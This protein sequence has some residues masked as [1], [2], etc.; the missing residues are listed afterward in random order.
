MIASETQSP[1]VIPRF[2]APLSAMPLTFVG[3]PRT[4]QRALP[5]SADAGAPRDFEGRPPGPLSVA[6]SDM[7][8]PLQWQTNRYQRQTRRVNDS[9]S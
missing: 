8:I 6:T 5:P 9:I 3:T 2:F 7:M 1:R 4:V